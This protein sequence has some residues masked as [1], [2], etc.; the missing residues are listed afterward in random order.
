[1]RIVNF[2]VAS[3]SKI[4]TNCMFNF[5]FFKMMFNGNWLYDS[6]A[7]ISRS[8]FIYVN[9]NVISGANAFWV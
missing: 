2:V 7:F 6:I 9:N 4:C 3:L 1:M 5:R 8:A